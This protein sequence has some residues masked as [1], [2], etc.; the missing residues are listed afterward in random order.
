MLIKNL[1]RTEYLYVLISPAWQPM[2]VT[3]SLI[4]GSM[5]KRSGAQGY[6]YQDLIFFVKINT[7]F[8]LIEKLK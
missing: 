5:C 2:S 7:I 8:K 4:N 1:G 6:I 3:G